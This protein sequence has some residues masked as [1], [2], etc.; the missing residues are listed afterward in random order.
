MIHF[1]NPSGNHMH[2]SLRQMSFESHLIEDKRKMLE[3][4]SLGG[5]ERIFHKERNDLFAK[6]LL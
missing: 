2:T 3:I 6:F 4:F 5:S 1:L